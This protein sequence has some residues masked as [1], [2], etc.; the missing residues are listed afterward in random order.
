MHDRWRDLSV[1]DA[2]NEGSGRISLSCV[3]GQADDNFEPM[4]R[5]TG[6]TPRPGH[7][8]EHRL[9]CWNLN[10][11]DLSSLIVEYDQRGIRDRRAL[12]YACRGGHALPRKV[13]RESDGPN[14]AIASQFRDRSRVNELSE[15]ALFGRRNAAARA[16]CLDCQVGCLISADAG[17]HARRENQAERRETQGQPHSSDPP[18]MKSP[19]R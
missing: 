7:L 3:A 11:Q 12:R 4:S 2:G 1:D 6:S 9:S 14:A 10:Q 17:G 5:M 15:C 16:C 13:A 19:D 8:P 18:L